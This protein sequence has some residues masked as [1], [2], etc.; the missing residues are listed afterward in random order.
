MFVECDELAEDLRCQLFVVNRITGFVSGMLAGIRDNAFKNLLNESGHLQIYQEN[1]PDRLNTF[2]IEYLINRPDEII[3]NL[4][5]NQKVSA[6]EKVLQFGA[7]L[8]N[9]EKNIIM[10]G[11]GIDTD[12][13][14]FRN[15]EEKITQGSFLSNSI[16]RDGII[17]SEKIARILDLKLNDPVIVFTETSIKSPNYMEYPVIGIFNTGSSEIDDNFFFINID[18]AEP[19]LYLENKATEIRIRLKTSEYA[20]TFKADI[21]DI[22]AD[23]SLTAS[24]WKELFGSFIILLD[25]MDFFMFFIGF[26][27]VFIS[28]TVITNAILMNVFERFREYGTMRA[29]GLKKRQLF[30]LIVNEGIIHGVIGSIIGSLIGVCFVFYF[31]EHGL[32][33]GEIGDAFKIGT[34]NILYF[35]FSAQHSFFNFLFG[36]SIAI[37]ASLYAAT[38]SLKYKLIDI[39]RYV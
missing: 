21:S 15:I 25:L 39:I 14:F 5:L 38:I 3:R 2:S 13:E 12:T 16:N 8:I 29:I 26:I 22:L 32:N 11:M 20:D 35:S 18:I 17:I 33:L 1:Y 6:A 36:V 37:A 34:G 28:A 27:I 30:L 9:Y 24:T 7:Q 4:E 10:A 19:L 31:T 23:N